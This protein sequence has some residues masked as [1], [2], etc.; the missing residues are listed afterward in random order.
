MMS[1]LLL[2]LSAIA[3]VAIFLFFVY[4]KDT[5]KEPPKLLAKSFLWGCIAILPILTIELVLQYLNI[6]SSAFLHSFY[7]AFIVAAFVEEGVKLFCLYKII[8]KHKEF[9][10]YYD[11]IV[12]AVFVSLGFALVENIFYVLEGGFGVS[13]LR[14]MLSI[15]AHGLFGVLMG[16]FFALAKFSPNKNKKFLW[17]SFIVPFLAH[18]LYDFFL[19]YMVGNDEIT[20]FLLFHLFIALMIFLWRFGIKYIKKHYAKDKAA[21]LSAEIIE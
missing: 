3:P 17:L 1:I 15:P 12:Y 8:W 4:R 7:E 20:I 21:I 11:G 18:G 2:L 10:Q 14:A 13:I 6:F 5:E 19:M 9:D 16:Y